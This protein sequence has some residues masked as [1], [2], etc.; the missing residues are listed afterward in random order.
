MKQNLIPFSSLLLVIS[1]LA[2]AA[3]ATG[4]ENNT[5]ES[6]LPGEININATL[7]GSID[8]DGD[9]SYIGTPSG[10]ETSFG[11][12]NLPENGV[13]SESS[14]DTI[15]P[16]RVVNLKVMDAPGDTQWSYVDDYPALYVSWDANTEDD[17]AATPYEIFISDFAP[18]S[19]GEMEKIKSTAGVDSYIEECGG[20]PLVYGKDY[21]V[22]VIARDIAGNYNDCFS[23]CGPVQT[24]EDMNIKLDQGWNM[25]SVPKRLVASNSRLE[26]VFGEGS[27]VLY[28]NGEC[29]EF[30]ETIEPC[31][32]Y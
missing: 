19:L 28:R 29:W 23:I 13:L 6:T 9:S 21:W 32:G 14:T 30:P 26:S 2:G 17:L 11:N 5:N 27:I 18:S 31:K 3:H 16:A 15:A 20:K 24:Y 4:D 7:L 12:G 1:L 25:K 10:N 22:A 8:P